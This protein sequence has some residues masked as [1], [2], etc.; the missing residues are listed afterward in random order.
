MSKEEVA[1]VKCKS[2]DQAIVDKAVQ[3]IIDLTGFKFKKGSKVLIK[4]NVVGT[5]P[6]KQIAATTNVA[7]IKAICKVLKNNGCK[8]YIG[9]S[10]FTDPECSFRSTKIDKVAE[11]YGKLVIFEQD[12]ITNIKNNKG[13][14]I[15]EFKISKTLKDVDLV[16]NVPK[17]KT[18][19]LTKY[20]GAI[21][22]LYGVIL[23]G[24]KQQ[25]HLKAKGNKRFSK[26][27][28]DIYECIQPELTIMDGIIGMEG[29]GPTSGDIK[30]VGY[31]LA[32]KNGVALDI[33]ATKMIGINP[34]KLYML[35]D[36]V[37]RKLC[38]S[39][40]PNIIGDKFKEIKFKI[41]TSHEIEKTRETI[42]SIFR[43]KPIVV[44]EKK[45]VKCGL[46]AR[47]CPAKAIKL[48]PYPKINPKKCIRCFCC[49]EICPQDALSLKK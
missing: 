34:K 42:R 21:K 14:I 32:S 11:K 40:D 10:P 36:A 1:I 26:M 13:K 30:K 47:K 19:S 5:F 27:L 17:L 4:P 25:L 43:K 7:V 18:H 23:G 24:I 8:I 3:K 12:K 15:K 16:I 38:S 35:K 6:K 49:M 28:V 22:N 9:D 31:L 37:K 2:Y 41:P 46:C 44:D 29:E 45:C 20:T 39:F 33:V 48:V